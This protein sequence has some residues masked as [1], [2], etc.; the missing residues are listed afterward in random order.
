MTAVETESRSGRCA[1]QGTVEATR[2][3]PKLGF[4]YLYFAIARSLAKR[5]PFRC[6]T[7]SEPVG[8]T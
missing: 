1:T 7:C 8:D 4:P 3:L 2:Q 6:P 5:R